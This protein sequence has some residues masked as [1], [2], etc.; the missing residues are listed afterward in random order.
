MLQHRPELAKKVP[1]PPLMPSRWGTCPIV[2]QMRP[3]MNPRI[4][5][6]GLKAATQPIRSAPNRRKKTPIRIARVR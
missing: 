1:D 3:S 2:T 5:G 6:V 4:T